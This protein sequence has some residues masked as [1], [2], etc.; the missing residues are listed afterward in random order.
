MNPP[1]FHD[2]SVFYW[3]GEDLSFRLLLNGLFAEH[4]IPPGAAGVVT[5]ADRALLF[6]SFS[7]LHD[8]G[9]VAVQANIC[10]VQ[11]LEGLLAI[12]KNNDAWN[13][14]I[15]VPTVTPETSPSRPGS[16]GAGNGGAGNGGAGAAAG[17]AAV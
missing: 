9:M 5:H 2:N 3:Y 13:N 7:V 1:R 10:S 6:A 4:N 11:C 12:L 8:V 17:N 14:G 15:V 16:G